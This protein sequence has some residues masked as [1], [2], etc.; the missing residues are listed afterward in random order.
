MSTDS[1]NATYFDQVY[2]AKDDPWDFTTSEYER[3]K[4][5]RTL[6]SLPHARYKN[7]F[8]I[9]CSIGVLT[10]QVAQRCEHL[11]SVDVSAKAIES[12]RQRCGGL[13]NVELRQMSVPNEFPDGIFDLV[14]LSEVGYY[15][16]P[17]DRARLAD[18]IAEHQSSAAD[19][20]L[21]HFTPKVDDYPATGDQVHDYFR[22]RPEWETIVSGRE[23][24]YR[25]DV[26][27]RVAP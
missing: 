9:G 6:D 26:L 22:S 5:A 3:D 27:R 1:L 7:A 21:V 25:I 13:A 10:A 12:A 15:F 2:A 18:R 16:S 8:E 19:L 24:R 17:E 4:Y 23:P 14:M 20:V 11:L